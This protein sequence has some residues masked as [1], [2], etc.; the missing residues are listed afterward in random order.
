MAISKITLNGVTQMDVTG[1]T[2]TA[3]KMLD[4][5]TAL[6]NDGTDI[7]GNIPSK[8]SADLTVSG[9]TVTV[10]AGL[11][12]GTATK[13]VAS[14]TAGTPTATKGNVSDHSVSITPSVTNT[15][16]Y[17]SGGTKNGTPVTVTASELVSG[18]LQVDSSGTKDVT[19]YESVSV[20]SGSAMPPASISGTGASVTAG[21]NKLTLTK[22][23]SN[24]PNVSEGYVKSGTAGNSSVSLTA[25]VNTR[26]SS[27]LTVSEATITAPAGYYG[28]AASKSVASGTAGTPTAAKG[29]VS[30]Y[31]VTVTPSVTNTTGYISGGTKT[32]SAV[33]VAASELVS[34]NLEIT[35]NGEDIDVT[36]YATVSVNVA[37]GGGVNGSLYQDPEGYLVLE[38]Y[39]N[40]NRSM[41]DPIRFFD[42]DGTIVASY[43]SVPDKMPSVPN[44]EGLTQGAWNY[45][46]EDI[47]TQYNYM[48]TCDVGA[49]YTT[50]S[51]WTEID[52]EVDETR[53]SLYLRVSHYKQILI[54][55]GDENVNYIYTSDKTTLG[56]VYNYQHTYTSPGKYTIKI[57]PYTA[58]DP[59][60]YAMSGIAAKPLI[61]TNNSTNSN[62]NVAY[63]TCVKDVRIGSGCHIRSFAFTD[64]FCLQTVSIPADCPI[65]SLSYAF[66]NDRSLKFVAFP[67][68]TY[69][70]ID[71]YVLTNGLSLA[72][73][74]IPVN[75]VSIG[76][77]AV[78]SSNIDRLSLPYGITSIGATVLQNAYGVQRIKLPAGL[79]SVGDGPF[80]GIITLYEIELPDGIS[81]IPSRFVYHCSALASIN[82]PSALASIGSEAFRGCYSLTKV[83]IPASVTTI[84]ANAFTECYGVKEY[85]IEASE[86]R[87]ALESDNVFT[88]ILDD[89]VIYVPRSENQVVLNA[90][91]ADTNWSTYASHMQEEPA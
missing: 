77:L 81:S 76:T 50:A 47:T 49:N 48:G 75:Y 3:N 56:T 26:T 65:D 1:K 38:E 86:T 55:W 35:E 70:N 6:K 18:T 44:H 34:G 73:M 79:T 28:S 32:G 74:S 21:T 22:T 37:G 23:V 61:H 20:P 46:L 80:S 60:E 58:G 12:E 85:H 67:K 4:G 16:G 19:N 87:T 9:P 31:A 78:A 41:E 62:Y 8:S 69:S 13:T 17:I 90:Y 54:N 43:T 88:G 10:P 57:K 15:G 89:C 63:S 14:G 25:D 83:T 82:L 7:I 64:C 11:Y 40:G 72:A 24:T 66:C 45:T 29:T 52:I 27:D 71:A 33:T 36:N 39:G 53:L 5:V 68:T 59:G 30:N 42:Y 84:G 2:V 91:K 51:G